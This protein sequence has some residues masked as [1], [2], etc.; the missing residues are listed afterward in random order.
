MG[1]KKRIWQ[2]C[3]GTAKAIRQIDRTPGVVAHIAVLAL[4]VGLGA[5]QV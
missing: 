2:T 4:Q 1:A 5:D 3:W